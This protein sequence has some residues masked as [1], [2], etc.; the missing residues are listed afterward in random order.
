M[1]PWDALPSQRATRSS[2]SAQQAKLPLRKTLRSKWHLSISIPPQ[3][4][5]LIKLSSSK[6]AH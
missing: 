2:N 6:A 1:M 3:G 5:V 4:L